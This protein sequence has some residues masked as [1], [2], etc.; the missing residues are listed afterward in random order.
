MALRVRHL[1]EP[2]VEFGTGTATTIKEGLAQYGPYSLRL[3]PA[4]PT[5]VRVGLVGTY[6]S[7][8][9]ARSFLKRCAAQIPSGRPSHLLAPDFLGFETVMH[10]SLALD[11]IWEWTIDQDAVGKA[12]D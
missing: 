11:P 12:L 2:L 7:V 10:A 3:G 5:T 8:A 4:H 9:G 6:L 1:E